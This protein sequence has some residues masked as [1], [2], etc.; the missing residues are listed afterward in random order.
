[1][2][3]IF[4]RRTLEPLEQI[5]KALLTEGPLLNLKKIGQVDSEKTLKITRF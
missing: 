2:V 5:I 1:M 4:L 3:A